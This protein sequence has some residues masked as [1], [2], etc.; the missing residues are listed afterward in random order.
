MLIT[1]QSHTH[2]SPGGVQGRW[3]ES[4]KTH[5]GDC[6]GRTLRTLSR[7]HATDKAAMRAGST[8]ARGARVAQHPQQTPCDRQS[9]DV[10]AVGRLA[11]I[12]SDIAPFSLMCPLRGVPTPLCPVHRSARLAPWL[13]CVAPQ[14]Q[15]THSQGSRYLRLCAGVRHRHRSTS[16]AVEA[17]PL[18]SLSSRVALA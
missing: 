6:T 2:K 11:H 18:P 12:Q 17:E 9:S 7:H 8:P 16:T 3:W 14:P 4:Q 5:A 15:P 1:Q 10:T 13:G